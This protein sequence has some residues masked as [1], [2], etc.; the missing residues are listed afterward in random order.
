MCDDSDHGFLVENISCSIRKDDIKVAE[1]NQVSHSIIYLDNALI[2]CRM[3]C[4]EE[5]NL[6][7]L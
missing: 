4:S 6:S 2:S 1:S 5:Q 3:Y 7:E